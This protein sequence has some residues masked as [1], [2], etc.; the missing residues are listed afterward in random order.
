MEQ[1][2]N[3]V[4]RTEPEPYN[5]PLVPGFW[6]AGGGHEDGQ[7][8]S[9]KYFSLLRRFLGFCAC[10]IVNNEKVNINVKPLGCAPAGRTYMC[11]L[12]ILEM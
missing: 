12:H 8:Q 2:K 3:V 10:W 7:K 4:K 1:R 11:N 6:I 5:E 9:F